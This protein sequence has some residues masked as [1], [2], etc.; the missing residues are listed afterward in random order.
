VTE[1]TQTFMAAAAGRTQAGKV[2]PAQTMTVEPWDVLEESIDGVKLRRRSSAAKTVAVGRLVALRL[3]DTAPFIIGIVRAL[4]N[5]ADG[6]VMSLSTIPGKPAP[7]A[8]R[9][10]NPSWSQAL[11]LPALEKAGIPRT[12]LVASGLGHR[13][14]TIHYWQEGAQQGKV[15]DVIERGADFDRISLA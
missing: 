15:A 7:I 1:R 11:S 9:G 14:R 6:L 5:A 10:A 8:A 3:G 4:E 2:M 13:G 12:L